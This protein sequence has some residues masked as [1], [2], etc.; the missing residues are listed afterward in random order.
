MAKF[1]T[2]VEISDEEARALAGNQFQ[3][4]DD[5]KIVTRKVQG[6]E[7]QIPQWK[8]VF[9]LD[10]FKCDFEPKD[11]KYSD[12]DH[13]KCLV[14]FRVSDAYPSK[15]QGRRLGTFFDFIWGL[16]HSDPEELKEWKATLN[17]GDVRATYYGR[18]FM[19]Q[20]AVRKMGS[21]LRALGH[22]DR[23]AGKRLFK[24]FPTI[25]DVIPNLSGRKVTGIVEQ[26][27]D[28]NGEPRDE[29]VA[30]EEA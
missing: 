3:V 12:Q 29:I 16:R 1:K 14:Q 8:E 7:V 21:L 19:T 20:R 13:E 26:G 11:S 23:L 30:F 15:N 18:Y 5:A 9:V 10:D 24:G 4:P 2:G 6:E 17:D 28:M 22:E 27:L 25:M